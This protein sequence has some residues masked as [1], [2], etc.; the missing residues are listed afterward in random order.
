MDEGVYESKLE[1]S[2][3]NIFAIKEMLK[4]T[5]GKFGLIDFTLCSNFQS[6]LDF[7]EKKIRELSKSYKN[8]D[9]EFKE[10]NLCTRQK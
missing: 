8:L 9:N 6:D 10:L 7:N 1:D 3:L 4:D 5:Y 2:M